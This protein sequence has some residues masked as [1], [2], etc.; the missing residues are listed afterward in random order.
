MEERQQLL[1]SNQEAGELITKGP[2]ATLTANLRPSERA[3]AEFLQF[4]AST[5]VSTLRAIAAAA[6]QVARSL[7]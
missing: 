7:G 3:Y 5:S 6:H 1:S 2:Y 4:K